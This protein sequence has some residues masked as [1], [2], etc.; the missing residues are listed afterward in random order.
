ME[1]KYP[2]LFIVHYS[3]N[4]GFSIELLI[5]IIYNNIVKDNIKYL[6]GGAEF[7][8]GGIAREP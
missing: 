4:K 2:Q 8:T 1:K 5:K 6:Q 7:P 3:L